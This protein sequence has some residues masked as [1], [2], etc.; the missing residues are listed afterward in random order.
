MLTTSS[1]SALAAS[2][3]GFGL[4]GTAGDTPDRS[5][6]KR[7]A[8]IEQPLVVPNVLLQD[9]GL[10]R[11]VSVD[12]KSVSITEVLNWLA[13]N[14]VNFVADTGNVKSNTK[15]TIHIAN[16]PIREVLDA[17]AA[18]FGGKWEKR[19]STFAFVSGVDNLLLRIENI[20]NADIAME[21]LE[22]LHD[23]IPFNFDGKDIF[24][25]KQMQDF[26]KRMKAWSEKF[27][28][29]FGG[30]GKVFQFKLDEKAISEMKERLKDM[31]KLDMEQL[32]K[33]HAIPFDGKR[34]P[35]GAI[36]IGGGDIRE[37][38]KSLTPAQW[39][40]HEKQGYL[41]PDDLTPA[42]K[43]VIG[44]LPN[45]SVFSITVMVDGKKLTIKNK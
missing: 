31:P 17:V 39:D 28:K 43:K 34:L 24:D 16:R 13:E 18:T 12:F 35:E 25:S 22:K 32:E 27:S 15:L 20:P 21:G 41:T 23:L 33:L 1:L 6:P 37:L 30:E 44:D 19:G 40:K 38:M 10:D 9:P 3:I 5:S 7:Q 8:T 14:G 11:L 2:A 42:Q 29:Q 36:K 26:E 4:V 45:S